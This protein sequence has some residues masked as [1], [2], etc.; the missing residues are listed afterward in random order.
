MTCKKTIPAKRY[1]K[2]IIE[3][4]IIVWWNVTW[5]CPNLR[6][7]CWGKLHV[8]SL[9]SGSFNWIK[10]NQNESTLLWHSM[11]LIKRH[12]L[13]LQQ[14]TFGV[15]IIMYTC[16]NGFLV[17]WDNRMNVNV[18]PLGCTW[19]HYRQGVLFL[20]RSPVGCR[21]NT[22]LGVQVAKPP[23]AKMILGFANSWIWPS[24]EQC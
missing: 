4:A 14:M 1:V 19:G 7:Q 15:I 9:F 21:G 13:K 10:S 2:I 24:W 22:A 6:F 8:Y 11:A 16:L 23:G 18:N 5:W 3:P 12:F 17:I 20:L